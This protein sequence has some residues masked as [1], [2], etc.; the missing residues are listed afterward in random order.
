MSAEVDSVN[1]FL[2]KELATI[3][4]LF[5]EGTTTEGKTCVCLGVE[6]KAIN[7]SSPNHYA[8]IIMDTVEKHHLH[9]KIEEKFS[10]ILRQGIVTAEK[11]LKIESEFAEQQQGLMRSIPVVSSVLNW[12]SPTQKA[13]PVGKSFDIGSTS[14]RN[15]VFS[16]KKPDGSTPAGPTRTP[17]GTPSAPA[18]RTPSGTPSGTP[19]APASRTPSISEDKPPSPQAPSDS[20]AITPAAIP[21]NIDGEEDPKPE[22]FPDV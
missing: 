17:S 7:N 3:D 10:G 22:P 8:K 13:A 2:A 4:S 19:S 16:P 11:Y 14:L 21:F 1:A 20:P 5:S 6:T 18:S 12:W 9:E 15:V